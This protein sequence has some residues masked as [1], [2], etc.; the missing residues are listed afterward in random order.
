MMVKALAGFDLFDTPSSEAD[1]I[2][3]LA[4]VT[5]AAYGA[6][7]AYFC[8]PV[9]NP[10]DVARFLSDAYADRIQAAVTLGRSS[11]ALLLD[12]VEHRDTVYLAVVDRDG[13]AISFINSLFAEFGSGIMAANSGVLFHSRGSSYRPAQAAAT[14]HHSGHGGQERACRHAVRRH[15]RSLSGCRSCALSHPAVA[16]RARS[17]GCGRRAAKL[18]L[19]GRAAT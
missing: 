2:H 4:E 6:R 10:F 12:E 16:R 14:H 13:N 18:R 9:V 17:A 1:Q 15:G 7:D 8:D 19:W 3:L 5:K 11:K